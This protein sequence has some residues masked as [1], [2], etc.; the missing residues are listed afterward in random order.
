MVK[1]IVNEE[2]APKT[3][4]REQVF[5]NNKWFA[6]DDFRAFVYKGDEKKL[7]NSHDEFVTLIS[8]GWEEYPPGYVPKVQSLSI[9]KRVKALTTRKEKPELDDIDG[10]IENPDGDYADDELEEVDILKDEIALPARRGRKKK[11]TDMIG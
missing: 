9:Q 11:Q 3:D 8:D 2:H 1:R 7:A 10:E 5:Y 4:E 6:K